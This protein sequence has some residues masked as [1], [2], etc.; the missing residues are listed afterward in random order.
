MARGILVSWPGID[1]APFA[2]EAQNLSH[3]II[4]EVLEERFLKETSRSRVLICGHRIYDAKKLG[5]PEADLGT[6]EPEARGNWKMISVVLMRFVRSWKFG[7]GGEQ[8]LETEEIW[9][10]ST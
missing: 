7:K 1:L 3:W 5:I 6:T 2:M 10:S 4:R 8:G 9:E